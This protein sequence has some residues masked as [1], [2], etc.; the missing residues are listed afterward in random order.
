M[1]TAV[2]IKTVLFGT[3][4]YT[5]Q[6]LLYI[7]AVPI[8][9]FVVAWYQ[10]SNTLVI[11]GSRLSIAGHTVETLRNTP[12]HSSALHPSACRNRMTARTSHL[13]G[14]SIVRGMFMCFIIFLRSDRPRNTLQYARRC[15]G[16]CL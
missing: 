12:A 10:L 1:K 14:D 16:G 6:L 4:R 2:K 13:A 3:F 7:V 15:T 9:T 11:E 5:F 8:E